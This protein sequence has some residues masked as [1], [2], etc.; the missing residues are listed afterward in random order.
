MSYRLI[1]VEKPDAARR[2]ASA[3]ADKTMKAVKKR[4]IAYYTFT[5]RDIKHIVVPAVGHLFTLRQ[6]KKGWTYPIFEIE[7]IESYKVNKSARFSQKYFL[8]IQDLA[9][10][11]SEFIV[12]TDYDLEGQINSLY[13]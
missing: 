8:N 7:W 12:A 11:A 2:V 4:G 10:N 5:R 1:I 3:L 6:K 9:E 13:L